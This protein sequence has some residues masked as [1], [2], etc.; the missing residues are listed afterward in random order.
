MLREALVI[1][2]CVAVLTLGCT[3]DEASSTST[4]ASTGEGV[5]STGASASGS[6]GGTCAGGSVGAGGSD[7]SGGSGGSDGASGS[8]GSSVPVAMGCDASAPGTTEISCVESITPGVGA[9][10]GADRFPEI[11]YGPPH[12]GGDHGGS[13]DVLSLGTDGEIVVGFGGSGVVDGEGADF[14]VFENAFLTG[15]KPFKELGQISVS[16]DGTTWTAFP[17][18]QDALPYTGCAGWHP[19]YSNPK[20]C[21]SPYDPVAAGGDVFD[22]ATIGVKTARFIKIVDLHNT[23]WTGGTTGFDLDAIAVIHAHAL[24]QSNARKASSASLSFGLSASAPTGAR[25]WKNPVA[26]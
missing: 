8:G 21:V 25:S 14:I 26:P 7:G 18:K 17:C 13:T 15:K 2:A 11:I 19:V 20:N 12:G 10:F 1:S 24:G 23:G 5:T 9:G 3:G 4:G 22:L 16:D 6:G